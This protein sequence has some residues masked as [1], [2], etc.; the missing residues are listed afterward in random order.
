MRVF[1]C[2]AGYED[3]LGGKV[4]QQLQSQG[5]S[6]ITLVEGDGARGL[7]AKGGSEH[8][9]GD[10]GD[11]AVQRELSAADVVVDLRCPLALRFL[12]NAPAPRPLL[13]RRAIEGSGKCLIVTSSV[14]VLGDTGPI[15]VDET[16]RLS[17]PA[18]YRW[19]AQLER[20]ILSAQDLR[21]VVVRPGIVHGAE[22]TQF[23]EGWLGLSIRG[24]R[25]T[26]I[27]PGTTRWSA[28]HVD[29]LA[30]LYCLAVRKARPG[31]LVHAAAETLTMRDVAEAVQRGSGIEGEPVGIS[32]E[33]ASRLTPI[34]AVLCQN[35]AILSETARNALGWEPTR[36]SILQEV[37][38]WAQATWQRPR[39]R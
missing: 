32:L 24:K 20:E 17:P 30:D 37:E 9:R 28:V 33:E 1:L 7:R 13:L 2:G 14:G 3:S 11:A 27:S 38:A 36:P 29:D 6:V 21:G 15:A 12:R 31:M 19:L 5:D 4:A 39:K 18:N 16:K 22:P 26:Y 23:L 10:I 34:S 8:V 25:G 35:H